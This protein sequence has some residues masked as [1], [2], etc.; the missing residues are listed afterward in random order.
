MSL[1]GQDSITITDITDVNPI[2]LDLTSS[3]PIYQ[4][5]KTGE[6]YEPDYTVNPL[7]ITPSLY[8]GIREV[9]EEEY[10]SKIEFYING[11]LVENTEKIYVENSILYMKQNLTTNIKIEVIIRNITDTSTKVTYEEVK[12]S[13]SFYYLSYDSSSYTTFI[14]SQDG[15]YDF[16]SNNSSDITLIAHLYSGSTELN[17]IYEWKRSSGTE[18]TNNSGKSINIARSDIGSHENFICIMSY[19][20]VNYVATCA[21]DDRTDEYT[22]VIISSGS[23][24]M[25]PAFDTAT[26]TCQILKNGNIIEVNESLNYSWAL[27][28]NNSKEVI[29]LSEKGASISLTLGEGNVPRNSFTLYCTT[30]IDGKYTVVSYLPIAYKNS[31]YTAYIQSENGRYDFSSENDSNIKLTAYLYDGTTELNPSYKWKRSSGLIIPEPTTNKSLEVGRTDIHSHENFI[32]EMTYEGIT[33]VTVCPIDDRTDEYTGVIVSNKSLVMSPIS[34]AAIFTCKIFKN[35]K[36]ININSTK[37]NFSYSWILYSN[38]SSD[39]IEIESNQKQV[40]LTIDGTK[41][42]K[43]SFTL[44]CTTT[45]DGKNI[46]VS[47]LPITYKNGGYTALINS[48]D[49]R[50]D[51]SSDKSGPIKLTAHL[52]DGIKEL[53]PAYLWKRSSGLA[54]SGPTDEQDLTI[55]RADIYSHENFI[56]EM[57]YEGITYI[58][59]CAIDDRTDLYTNTI[60]SDASLVM[61]PSFKT[62]NFTC[63]I[64]K[65]QNEVIDGT[66]EYSWI[67]YENGS[68]D[69]IRI[70]GNTKNITIT[71]GSEN[72]PKDSFTLYCTATIDDKFTTVAYLPISYSVSY[73]PILTPKTIFIPA[74]HD[75]SYQGEAS[76]IEK[77]LTFFLQDESGSPIESNLANFSISGEGITIREVTDTDKKKYTIPFS[78]DALSFKKYDVSELFELSYTYK[79]QSFNEEFYIVKSVQGNDG[80]D[81]PSGSSY[82]LILSNDYHRFAGKEAFAVGDQKVSTN[83]S[84]FKGDEEMPIEVIKIGSLEGE[85]IKTTPESVTTGLQAN[86]NQIGFS[87]GKEITFTTID[88]AL[89]DGGTLPVEIKVNLN[90]KEQVFA[91]V[92][93]YDINFE[94]HSYFLSF[95]NGTSIIYYPSKNSFSPKKIEFYAY[96][97]KNG[98]EENTV[99]TDGKVFYSENGGVKK[100]LSSKD[101]GAYYEYNINQNLQ[102][103][104]TFYLYSSQADDE[105]P[106]E[107]YLMD[108]E[109]IPILTSLEGIEIG[110]E[111]LIRLSRTLE[112]G[113]NKWFYKYRV[114]DE[115][116]IV[117]GNGFNNLNFNFKYSTDTETSNKGECY[118]IS[119]PFFI[120]KEIRDKDLCFSYYFKINSDIESVKKE[121]NKKRVVFLFLI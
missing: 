45:I 28:A 97:R 37:E 48:E 115:I 40:E 30:K 42:P 54:I 92:F 41:I 59:T 44:Y 66:I 7:I 18:I 49:G 24:I 80:K 33:Y 29:N 72:M 4:T 112:S 16:S 25:S 3:Q 85:N 69:G 35:G 14:D 83:I 61:T 10:R 17:P 79:G 81:G 110:G 27:Y 55:K 70:A 46:V 2:R 113:T 21:V 96:Y 20:N 74:N 62:A 78:I 94:G 111:N 86:V 76:A 103:N 52:Y 87:T 106:E 65:N 105:T 121:G 93:S 56:C 109:T 22:G 38:G 32:C 118:I 5:K 12:N 114:S 1:L 120:D 8:F 117:E 99:Y 71:L 15:R 6:N 57:L 19:D 104:V 26:F 101:N 88:R 95:V 67:Y 39:G 75:G 108:R 9:N 90:G 116:Q 58:A 102:N 89:K 98:A 84:F 31:G 51:F 68:A 82:S 13:I 107:K 77:E 60:I 11:V 63:K 100:K 50:Y 36:E 73:T 34:N 119:P 23:L 47:Y 91:T 53:V 43:D 64:F